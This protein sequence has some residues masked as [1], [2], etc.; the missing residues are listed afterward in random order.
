MKKALKATEAWSDRKNSSS[1]LKRQMRDLKFSAEKC[2]LTNQ[3]VVVAQPFQPFQTME[4]VFEFSLV[5]EPCENG[6]R[7]ARDKS[8]DDKNDLNSYKNEI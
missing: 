8:R 3:L 1:V 6:R 7:F 4:R 5:R 2:V